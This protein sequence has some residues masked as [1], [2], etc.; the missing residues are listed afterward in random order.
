MNLLQK[1]TEL[2]EKNGDT[3][4][5]LSRKS[6]VP[7]TTIDGLFKKGFAG[8]RISTI[9]AI[10]RTYHVSTDYLIRDEI[11][12]PQF[13]LMADKL[14]P[15]ERRLLSA[16]RNAEPGAQEIALETLENHPAKQDTELLA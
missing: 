16:W 7:Y 10:G 6:G 14:Q 5:S 9:Q 2:M 1:L 15:I 11:D 3:V 13:G 4:A 12:D 8:A